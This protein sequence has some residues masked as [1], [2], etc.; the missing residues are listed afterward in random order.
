MAAK[1][2]HTAGEL[3]SAQ[4][5]LKQRNAPV[6]IDTPLGPLCEI[7]FCAAYVLYS[8]IVQRNVEPALAIE[9]A[10]HLNRASPIAA[11]ILQIWLEVLV[12]VNNTTLPSC[13]QA[14]TARRPS[15]RRW[16]DTV[17]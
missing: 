2:P 1:L 7:H 12:P 6:V 17:E 16:A 4:R 9:R 5:T 14:T 3:A 13:Q 8:D 11:S 15:R 10:R